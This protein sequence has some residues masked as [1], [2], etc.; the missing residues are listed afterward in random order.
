MRQRGG[1]DREEVY[2][3]GRGNEKDKGRS[4][5]R[6]AAPWAE[7]LHE[8]AGLAPR[9]RAHIRAQTRLTNQTI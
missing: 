6:T 7:G 3:G 2:G 4:K 9:G 5:G 1:G 8:L